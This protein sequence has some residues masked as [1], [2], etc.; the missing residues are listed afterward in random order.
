MRFGNLI[1]LCVAAML[2]AIGSA[3]LAA[4]SCSWTRQPNGTQFGVC[5]GDDGR[6]YCVSCAGNNCS[7]VTCR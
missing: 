1:R 3:A 6:M 7:R 5:V 2:M 4:P